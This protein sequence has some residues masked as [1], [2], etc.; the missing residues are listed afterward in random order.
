VLSAEK[1]TLPIEK[2]VGKI[3]AEVYYS[4]PPGYPLLIYGEVISEEHI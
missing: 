1:E 4:C 2:C 3:S